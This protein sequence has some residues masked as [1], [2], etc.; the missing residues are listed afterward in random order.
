MTRKEKVAK[1]NAEKQAKV[2]TPIDNQ[3]IEN[4][5]DDKGIATAQLQKA[6][7]APSLENRS[8][9]AEDELTAIKGPRAA[10]LGMSVDENN[11]VKY[12]DYQRNAGYAIRDIKQKMPTG[13]TQQKATGAPKVVR[14]A[15]P[16]PL[17]FSDYL[18]KQRENLKQDKTDAEKMQKYYAL[19]DVFNALGKMGGAAVGGAIGGNMLDSAPAVGE[20]QQN[21]GYL[22]AFERAKQANDRLRAL[23]EQEFT[24]AYNRQQQEEERDYRHREQELDRQ[25]QLKLYDYKTQI[26]QAIAEKDWARSAQLKLQMAKDE[27]AHAMA[28]QRLRNSG[29]L[30]EKQ[31]GYDISKWQAETYNTTPIGFSD[32]TSIAVPDNYY[33]GL[34]N[35]FMNADWNGRRVTKDNVTEYIKHHPEEAMEFLSRF[36]IGGKAATATSSPKSPQETSSTSAE[37][38]GGKKYYYYNPM[39]DKTMPAPAQTFEN[40]EQPQQQVQK[41][42]DS[43][44]S[45]E[46]SVSKEQETNIGDD[47]LKY[48]RK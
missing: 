9:E 29:A 5:I 7:G 30:A 6:T 41:T 33:Q 43:V 38:T 23:D 10:E 45:S 25:W 48:E 39:A 37:Q 26:E 1:K 47:L 13:A 24:L 28:L 4:K 40:Q 27:Q 15:E 34:V 31:A 44:G 12:P 18:A 22:D 14:P 3:R 32:G 46:K 19:T 21:R 8:I 35:Y 20:Y 11:A 36:G 16:K 42:S 17:T 2:V